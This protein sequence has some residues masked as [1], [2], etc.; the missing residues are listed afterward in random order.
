MEYSSEGSGHNC[1]AQKNDNV[2]LRSIGNRLAEGELF[3]IS[4]IIIH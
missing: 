1:R 3:V 4:F 2:D